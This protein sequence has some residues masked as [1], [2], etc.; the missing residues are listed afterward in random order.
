MNG[1]QVA[2]KAS[3]GFG[4]EAAIFFGGMAAVRALG[5]AEWRAF[6]PQRS[7]FDTPDEYEDVWIHTPDGV[8]LHAWF[9]PAKHT[10]PGGRTPAVLHAH[11]SAGNLSQHAR[12]TRFLTER[13]FHVLLFDYRGYGRSDPWTMLGRPALVRDTRAALAALLARNDVDP[14]RVGVLGMSVGASFGLDAAVDEPRVRSVVTLSGFAS[15]KSISSRIVPFFGPQVV[16]NG[17]DAQRLIRRLG[18]RE[19]LVMHGLQDEI[20]PVS[21]AERIVRA[22]RSAGV[23]AHISLHPNADHNNLVIDLPEARERIADFFD[24]TLAH[25]SDDPVVPPPQRGDGL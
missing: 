3:A 15:W 14:D 4:R 5:L 25:P 22:A 19:A 21:H 18:D 9:M 10:P 1:E 24:R 7:D 6:F 2:K 17:V 20:V 16:A 11:G 8:R 12:Y 23:R 13:G